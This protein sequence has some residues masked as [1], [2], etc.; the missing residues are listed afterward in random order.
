MKVFSIIH[1]KE[2]VKLETSHSKLDS[3]ERLMMIFTTHFLNKG[4][5][6]RIESLFALL[7]AK[8]QNYKTAGMNTRKAN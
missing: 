7:D 1:D 3:M 8:V 2:S 6:D 5:V 4:K